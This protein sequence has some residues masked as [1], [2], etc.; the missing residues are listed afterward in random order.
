MTEPTI[1]CRWCQGKG[2][3]Q[4]SPP[5]AR[6][7]NVI[8]KLGQPTCSEIFQEIKADYHDRTVANQYVKRLVN[9]NLVR[10]VAANGDRKARYRAV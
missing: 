7:L 8:Q 9:L 2:R 1:K 6:V 5:V 3:R 10:K 4:L